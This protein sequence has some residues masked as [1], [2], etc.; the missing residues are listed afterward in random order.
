MD[1][2]GVYRNPE[3]KR[4][5]I[6]FIIILL[7]MII[8]TFL[9][10][11]GIVKKINNILLN[12]NKVILA[13]IIEQRENSKIIKSFYEIDSKVDI[14]EAEKILKD[15]GYSE[16]LSF[17]SN[18]LNNVFLKDVLSIFIPLT[19]TTMVI[20]YIMFIRELSTIYN[21][22][23]KVVKSSTFMSSGEY[24]K[25]QGDYEEGEMSILISSLNYM[26]ERVNNS[27]SLLK[28]EKEYLRDFVSDISHQLKT[29]LSSLIMFNDLMKQNEDMPYKDRAMFLE[30]C[31][32]QL[33]RMQWLIMNLLK[34]GRLEAGAI[35]FEEETQPLRGTIEL[36]I[37]SLVEM[38]KEKNQSLELTG[39]LDISLKHDREWL[40]E[41]IS[42]IVKNAIEHTQ[43]GGKIEINVRKRPLIT[44]I[45]IIDNGSGMSESMQKNV[46]KRFF[47]GSNSRN[48]KSIGIGLSLSKSIVE[49]QGGEIKLLSEEGKGTTFIISFMDSLKSKELQ[50]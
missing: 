49:E 12:E 35:K 47:K 38:A 17:E 44:K 45:Y 46:F 29:P 14:Q 5:T 10:S 11:V 4:I 16:E 33:E 15:Y 1:F 26:G 22:M 34:V 7:A 9:F 37:S 36:S 19:I 25:I 28:Q 13:N 20:L 18:E 31:D 42:N 48:P 40:A 39:D 30:K 3:A 2:R 23:N 27:I 32:E 21:Q 8:I 50:A 24:K 43:V 41:A 6:K